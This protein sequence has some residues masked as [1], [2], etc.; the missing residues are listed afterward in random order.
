MNKHLRHRAVH[1]H[2]LHEGLPDPFTTGRHYPTYLSRKVVQF[3]QLRGD[4]LSPLQKQAIHRIHHDP[5]FDL[6][7]AATPFSDAEVL[8][9]YFRFFD[10]LFFFGTLRSSGR[11]LL[12]H[13]QPPRGAVP[14][15]RG[16]FVKYVHREGGAGGGPVQMYDIV[17]HAPRETDRFL[18]FRKSLGFLM[19]AMCHAFLGLW[20]CKA[21]GCDEVWRERGSGFAWQD[22]AL[23]IEDALA[24]REFL[25][26][27]VDLGRRDMLIETVKAHP[28][29]LDDKVLQGWRFDPRE[30]EGLWAG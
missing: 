9:A 3:A 29:H 24:D 12:R 18:R 19:Q 13:E 27:H 1:T 8:T 10:D 21:R 25:N 30:V 4:A 11:C 15:P 22:M 17:L 28:V 6:H 7:D 23:A 20:R 14:D 2:H 26:L 5:A 16:R